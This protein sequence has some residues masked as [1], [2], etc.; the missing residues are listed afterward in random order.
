MPLSLQTPEQSPVFAFLCAFLFKIFQ[1]KRGTRFLTGYSP[2][3]GERSS[4]NTGLI[5]QRKAEVSDSGPQRYVFN[6]WAKSAYRPFFMTDTSKQQLGRRSFQRRSKR[7]IKKKLDRRERM[8]THPLTET[9]LMRSPF[10][11]S[12]QKYDEEYICTLVA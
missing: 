8:S 2:Q 1:C 3:F 5:R 11:N 9:K 10:T 6:S 7:S 12:I 4:K